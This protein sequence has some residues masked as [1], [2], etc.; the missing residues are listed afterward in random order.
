M[1]EYVEQLR[2]TGDLLTVSRT[3]DPEFELAAV[4]KAAQV[5][6][7]K[8][9]LFE[10]IEGSSMPVVTNLYGSHRRLCHLIGASQTNFCQRWL[11]VAESVATSPDEYCEQV[12]RPNDRVEGL[13]R[14]LPL[15]TYHEKDGGSYFT[16]AI[17]VAK[18]PDSGTMNISFHR[19][20]FISDKELRIRLGSSHDMARF[21]AKAEER[22]E[23][24]EV[25]LLIGVRPEIFLAACASPSYNVSELS[26]AAV[27]QGSPVQMYP[28][29]TIDMSVPV[30]TE[31]VVEGRVL[32]RVK[33]PEGPFGEFL[34]Y[35]VPVDENH[36]FE[37]T[38][39]DWRRAPVF[40]SLLCGS[41][42]DLR[43][44]EAV[45]A[46]RIYK[47]VSSVVRGVIDVS[48]RPNVM[49]TIIRIH[50]QY[51]GHGKH[52]IL[53]AV[54][55]H[56]DYNKVCIAVDED[57]DIYNLEEVMWAYLTRGRADTRAQILADVPGF[58]RDPDKDHWGRLLI[59]A[60]IPWG[61]EAD[62]DRKRIPGEDQI[63]LADYLSQEM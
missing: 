38:H 31:I 41:P 22:D 34:G 24:L 62:F 52:A 5:R 51:E 9:V 2:K 6:G 7:E 33:R 63:N 46:A 32:P 18:E 4:T 1:R 19:S 42:E 44:L 43:P 20:M 53:A 15:I 8:A 57:I 10:N 30:G 36:V 27:V 49:I 23:P 11:D 58:Y 56:L 25:A 40:H 12:A 35:Y 3:V 37:V 47:H 29:K 54:G 14:D 48:C 59:D 60:T 39:V 17:Y 13:L 45:T 50:K 55:S 28:C 26:Y 16:S 61:R 21:Q